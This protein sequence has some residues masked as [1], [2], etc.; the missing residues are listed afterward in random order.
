MSSMKR[1]DIPVSVV[2]PSFNDSAISRK[3]LRELDSV[4]RSFARTYEI[5]VCD[6]GSSDNNWKELHAAARNNHQI[7]LFRHSQN[8]GI[9]ATIRELYSK[10]QNPFIVLFSLD[11]EWEIQDVRRLLSALVSYDIVVGQRLHK[12]YP[13]HRQL[14]SFFHNLLNRLLFGIN[15]YDAQSIKAFRR[16]LLDTI[17]IISQSVFYEA[18]RIIRAKR[19]GYRISAIP[20]SH[21]TSEKLNRSGFR[22]KLIHAA[23]EDTITLWLHLTFYE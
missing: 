17:P 19:M 2:V 8:M 4:V 9:A 5:I 6:D 11:L 15:T 14:I 12:A 23:L 3:R 13:L 18:E 16:D 10:A 22:Y 21:N 1:F 20:I 7:K